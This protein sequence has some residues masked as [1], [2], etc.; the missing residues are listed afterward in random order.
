MKGFLPYLTGIFSS[1][2][3]LTI[4]LFFVSDFKECGRSKQATQQGV[5]NRRYVICIL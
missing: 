3:E 4:Y 1:F 5:F 2:F